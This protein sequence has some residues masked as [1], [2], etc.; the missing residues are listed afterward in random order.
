MVNGLEG[1]QFSNYRVSGAMIS[2]L[3]GSMISMLIGYW[4]SHLIF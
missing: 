1:Y 2:M 3:F 4:V